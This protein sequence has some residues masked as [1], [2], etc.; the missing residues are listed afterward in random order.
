MHIVNVTHLKKIFGSGAAQVAAVNDVSFTVDQGEIVLIMGPSGSGKT[1]LLTLLGG[2][3]TATAGT[4]QINSIDLTQV[5]KQALPGIRLQE[6]GFVFQSFNV[7]QNLTALENVQIVGELSGM[8]PVA[9]RQRAT[10]LL[11]KLHLEQRL[12][13]L[14]SKLSGGQQQRVAIARALMNEP[15]LI[16]ADEPTGNLDSRS[17]HEVM[18]LFHNL[19]KQDGR[20][21]IIVSHDERIK[22]IADR[23][24]W[25]ED[26]QIHTAPPEPEVTVVDPVCGMKVDAKYAPFST[27]V[28]GIVYKFCSEDCQQR[29]TQLDKNK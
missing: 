12:H 26:G 22:D 19:A 10:H 15:K 17:G 8:K 5:K 20:T 27:T 18:M 14:P 16:L 1:T 29:F 2:L 3:L 24:L 7:L 21:V 23:V 11:T 9:A 25:I 4:I 6:I 28:A 13:Y